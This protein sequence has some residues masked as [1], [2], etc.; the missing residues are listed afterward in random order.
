MPCLAN[1]W[2]WLRPVVFGG[3]MKLAWPRARR[4]GSTTA[5]TT[6]MSAMP[7]FVAQVLVPLSTHSP[8]ASSYV[9][10]VR[11]APTS[12]PASGSEEQN[13]AILRSPGSPNICGAHSATCSS[14]RW[15]RHPRRRAWC[16]RCERPMPA[17]PQNSSSIATGMPRPGLGR[18]TGWRRSPASRARP[19][20]PPPAPATG[21]PPARPTRPLPAGSRRPRRCAPSRVARRGRGRGRRKAR[22]FRHAP[23]ASAGISGIHRR[24]RRSSR[25]ASA[26]A[27]RAPARRRARPASP[28]RPAAAATRPVRRPAPRR[29]PRRASGAAPRPR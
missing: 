13:A 22:R 17:S 16:P 4:S 8:V 28:R 9:A 23:Q 19:W 21:T 26:A 7:P 6:W 25:P 18:T 27:C 15:R 20:R 14:C 24:V 11:I 2:P 3:T 10:R 5:V 29:G 12:L 1:F